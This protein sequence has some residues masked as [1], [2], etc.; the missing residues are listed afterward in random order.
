MLFRAFPN[1]LCLWAARIF[2]LVNFVLS[3]LVLLVE[4]VSRLLLR[5]TGGRAFTG[6]IFGNREEMRAVMRESAPSFTS[7]EH[8]MINRVLDLQHFTVRQVAIPLEKIVTVESQTPLAVAWAFARE[9]K[10]SRLPV[11]EMRDGR[12]R[13]GGLLVIGPLLFRDDMDLQKPASAYMSPAFY[14][15]ENVR[16]ET[17]LRLMQRAGHRLA[18]VLAPDGRETGIVTLE[19][20]L[21]IMFGEIKL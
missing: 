11:W 10:M 2:R 9:K 12:R 8:A 7:D 14:I 5:L 4:G 3:P 21:R 18:V 19:D 17:A 15:N 13:I 6:Q 1:Q 16:L 20:I